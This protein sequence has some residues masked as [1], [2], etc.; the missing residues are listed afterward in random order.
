MQNWWT[1]VKCSSRLILIFYHHTSFLSNSTSLNGEL[2]LV[3]HLYI[4]NENI[5]LPIYCGTN[6]RLRVFF[7]DS[8]NRS[9]VDNSTYCLTKFKRSY[10]LVC[11]DTWPHIKLSS[12]K[13]RDI[14]HSIDMVPYQNSSIADIVRWISFIKCNFLGIRYLSI[15]KLEITNVVCPKS[16]ECSISIKS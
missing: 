15:Y 3:K 2:S 1:S 4:N 7:V 11:L 9:I 14:P 5:F 8:A 13:S 12:T 6:G 16:L 10:S